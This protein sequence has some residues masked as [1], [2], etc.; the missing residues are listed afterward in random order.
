MSDDRVARTDLRIVEL[1]PF[2]PLTV[3][4]QN[5]HFEGW[6]EGYQQGL[7]ASRRPLLGYVV[8][9]MIAAIVGAALMFTATR[10]QAASPAAVEPFPAAR[11]QPEAPIGTRRLLPLASPASGNGAARVVAPPDPTSPPAAPIEGTAT[12]YCSSASTCTRGHDPSDLVAAIDTSTGIGRGESVRVTSAGRA[13]TVTVVDVCA[14]PGRRVIDL[15]S[16]AFSQL[17]PL[18]R[19]VIPVVLE[20][21]AVGGATVPPTDQALDR[22]LLPAGLR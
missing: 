19:G 15:T 13:I 5:A 9:A 3:E 12:W 17:A 8:V 16:G 20:R 2:D 14:C 6:E 10:V 11:P 22:E 7:E 1:P 4:L 21:V 18:S